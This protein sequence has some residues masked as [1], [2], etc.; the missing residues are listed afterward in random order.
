MGISR[1][2]YA[3]SQHKM[4]SNLQTFHAVYKMSV[5]VCTFIDIVIYK[6]DIEILLTFL[7]PINGS[8]FPVD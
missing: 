5:S 7:K 2:F 8:S 4:W 3:T 6:E 1:T